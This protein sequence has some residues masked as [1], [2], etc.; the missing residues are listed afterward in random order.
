MRP[1]A[2]ILIPIVLVGC[3]RSSV[4]DYASDTIQITTSAASVCGRS[5][6]QDVANRR[7]AIETI[8]RG[9]DRYIVLNAGYENDVRVVGHTPVIANTHGSGTI[10]GMG[11][12]AYVS[13]HS[14]TYYSGGTPIVG[15]SHTQGIVIKMFRNG[16][17]AGANAIDARRMLA[18]KW[19]SDEGTDADFAAELAEAFKDASLLAN[20]PNLLVRNPVKKNE[21]IVGRHVTHKPSFVQDNGHLTVMEYID[22]SRPRQKHIKERSGWMAYMFSDIKLARLDSEAVSIIKPDAEQRDVANF[23][24]HVLR[25]ESPGHQLV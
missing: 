15:G 23:A 11:N 6:A 17:A 9:Y 2:V 4:L 1:L 16:D 20:A 3:A 22:L 18:Y 5:G 12:S 14:T 10:T 13:G 25:G 8:N 7:A 19:D 24:S 21:N